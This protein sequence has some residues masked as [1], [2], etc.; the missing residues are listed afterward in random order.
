MTISC[1]GTCD[2]NDNQ[3]ADQEELDQGLASD[4]DLN[5]IL[6]ECDLLEGG[7]EADCNANGIFDACEIATGSGTDSDKDGILDLCQCDIHP[8]ACCPADLDGDGAV[9]GSDLSMVLGGWGTDDPLA[10]LDGNGIVEGADLAM[11]LGAWGGC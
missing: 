7:A 2:C 10:D 11:V 3:V 5:G 4:C 8:Q 6:D 9:G 1:V